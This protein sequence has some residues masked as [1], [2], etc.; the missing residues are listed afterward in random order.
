M[1][2]V[3]RRRLDW[4][5]P[6]WL[7]D[8]NAYDQS[9]D[10][11]LSVVGYT[12]AVNIIILFLFLLFFS[13]YRMYSPSTFT[14]KVDMMPQRT[15]PRIPNDTLFGWIK[16]LYNIDDDVVIDKAGYDV[17]FLLRFYRLSLRV[18]M[19]QALFSWIVLLPIN[20]LEHSFLNSLKD[21]LSFL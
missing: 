3:Y 19:C 8:V 11:D 10:E 21:L 20:K 9:M 17:L 12:I 13:I 18:F 16:D 2:E 6:S 14:P 1:Q 7:E 4:L 5:L 15:P